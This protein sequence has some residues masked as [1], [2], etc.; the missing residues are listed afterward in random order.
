MQVPCTRTR[1]LLEISRVGLTQ[2]QWEVVV[3][4]SQRK[5]FDF[6]CQDVSEGA[7]EGYYGPR[8]FIFYTDDETFLNHV[9]I[10]V[11]GRILSHVQASDG[12]SWRVI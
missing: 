11:K 2:E 4:L 7:S 5:G 6:F 12:K 9:R 3:D 10:G 8:Q 1:E